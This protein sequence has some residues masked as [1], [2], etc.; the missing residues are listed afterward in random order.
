[1]PNRSNTLTK[2]DVARRVAE[3]MDEPI[4][5]SEP[6]VNAVNYYVE[7]MNNYGPPG[8]SSNGHN[9]NRAL[10]ASGNCATWV[11][12]TS[13]AG[14]IFNPS[15]SRVADTTGFAPGDPPRTPADLTVLAEAVLERAVLELHPEVPFAVVALGRFAG[16]EL[17]YASDLDLVFVHEAKT[18]PERSEAM[19]LAVGVLRF[20]G[21][22]TGAQRIYAVDTNLRP[23]GRDGPLTRSLDGYTTYF[24]RWAHVWE[25]QAMA[26]ARPVAGDREL[27]DRFAGVVADAVWGRPFTADDER[28]VRR[29]KARI[30][31]ERIPAGEDPE[32]H[33][34]L[35]RGSL[36]DVEW[37]AQL[38]QLRTGIREPGTMAALAALQGD[39]ALT[40]GDADVL[41]SAY[42]FCEFVRN[43]W[44]LVGNS[45]PHV[46]ALPQRPG[47]LDRL[48]RSLGTTPAQLRADYRRVTRRSRRV[49]ERL[50]YGST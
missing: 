6:W 30:E 25:R 44:Y 3:I 13:A 19:R 22:A 32:F 41:G 21:G 49:V 34:K 7:L 37:T 36:S 40:A 8:V 4:Y 31:R 47:A 9:E 17:A 45:P 42:R 50:F 43:R 15:E 39:G 26:R 28:E 48:A 23:E 14:Y 29:L 38:L 18:S 2:K 12:A 11:D 5:K 10:F 27:G 33:L 16:E 35:G 24:A 20:V 1:M 46:D